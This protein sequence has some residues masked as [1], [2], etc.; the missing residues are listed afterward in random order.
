M[1]KR[2]LTIWVV[3]ALTGVGISVAAHNLTQKKRTET[4]YI[5]TY[6]KTPPPTLKEMVLSADAVV[7]GRIVGAKPETRSLREVRGP[8]PLTLY[9]LKVDE[10]LQAFGGRP[11]ADELTIIRDGGERDRGGYVE[12]IEQ[13][14]FSQFKMGNTYVLF[15]Q[16]DDTDQG[17]RVAWGPHGAFA[18]T[19]GRIESLGNA[20]ISKA[21]NGLLANEFIGRLRRPE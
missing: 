19:A 6:F 9:R 2:T 8:R 3:V 20:A 4:T 12:R 17:W 21:Q 15:L 13:D 14:G 7:T 1:S 16:W 18:I 10:V 5:Y 11:V